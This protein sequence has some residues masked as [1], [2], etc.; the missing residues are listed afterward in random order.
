MRIRQT[1]AALVLTLAATGALAQDKVAY[2]I[3]DSDTQALAGLRNVKNHLDTD[4]KAQITVV[5]HAGGV[6]F[7][8]YDAQDRN[9]NPYEVAVQQLVGRGVKF[10]VCEITLK[11]RQLERKQFIPEAAFTPS[12]VVRLSKLQGQGYSYIKP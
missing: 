6:D 12:G 2:H 9:G 3:N 5:T 11:N 7:L 4:P 8:M 1:F 10:E